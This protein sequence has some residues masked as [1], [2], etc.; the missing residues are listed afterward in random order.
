[1]KKFLSIFVVICISVGLNIYAYSDISLIGVNDKVLL[2]E[3]GYEPITFAGSICV[4][5][6]VFSRDVGV[7][8]VYN[9][10]NKI[11]TMYNFDHI[12]TLDISAGTI[13]DEKL[14]YYSGSAF[15]RGNVIYVPASVIC[16]IFGLK[17]SYM[18]SNIEIIRI[19]NQSATLSN[20]VFKTLA[21]STYANMLNSNSQNN[22]NLGLTTPPTI[23]QPNVSEDVVLPDVEFV[24]PIDVEVIKPIFIS[25]ITKE[26][27]DMFSYAQLTYYVDENSFD[28]TEILRYMYIKNH[29]I[30]IFVPE[31]TVNIDEYISNINSKLFEILG[32]KTTITL[33]ENQ[34]LEVLNYS[35]SS[36]SDY[37]NQKV[38]DS[39]EK[40]LNINLSNTENIQSFFDFCSANNII[41]Q[42]IDEF[43]T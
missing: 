11:L 16:D 18:Y 21:D 19:S 38:R 41:F 4:P 29:T 7:S 37:N 1:M 42:K 27:I 40:V 2:Y 6:T 14:N 39:I 24:K 31:S 26:D 32:F 22:G 12:L 33:F 8:S 28:D 13:Q 10:E 25:N 35:T 15:F 20:D 43:S 36:F 9:S 5:Y 34:E 17:Y 3:K 23:T 30:G